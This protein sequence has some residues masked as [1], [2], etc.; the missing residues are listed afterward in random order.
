MKQCDKVVFDADN[1]VLTS[2]EYWDLVDKGIINADL[3]GYQNCI[4][5]ANHDGWHETHRGH[6]FK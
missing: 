4:K 1:S 5:R 6:L 3:D 2:D